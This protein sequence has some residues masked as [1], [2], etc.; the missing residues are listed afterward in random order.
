M[1]ATKV[2]KKSLDA[3]LFSVPAGYTQ[4][5]MPAGMPQH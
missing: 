3:S 2:E 4:M 1:I 5:Q